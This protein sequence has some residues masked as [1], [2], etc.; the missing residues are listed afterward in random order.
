LT[1]SAYREQR[2][3]ELGL[4]AVFPLWGTDTSKLARDF[5]NQGHKAVIVCTDP[6][7]LDASFAGRAYDEQL[8]ADLPDHVDAC[9]ENGEFHTFVHA[10]PIFSEPIDYTIGETTER[11][12]F[13][14]CDLLPA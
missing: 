1:G 3:A 2:L 5:I 11:D 12:G 7:A 6:R 4:E 9:G 14:F 8:L 10:G 13:V